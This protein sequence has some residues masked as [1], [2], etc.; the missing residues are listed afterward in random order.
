MTAP[1]E[2][3]ARVG[4]RVG[5]SPLWLPDRQVWL[6]LDLQGRF[7]HRFDPASATDTVIAR[8]LPED[9]ACLARWTPEAALLVSVRGFHRLEIATGRVTPLACPIDLPPGTIFNDGKV[10]RHGALWLGSSDAAEAAPLGRLWRIDR[11]RVT[12]VAAGFTVSNGP[13]FAPDGR[14]AWFADT[15]GRRLLRFTLDPD[16]TP[17]AQGDFARVPAEEGYPDGMTTDRDGT[18]YVGHWDG[19]RISRWAPDGRALPPIA[20]PARNVTALAF[21]GA[22]LGTAAITTAALFPGQTGSAK[23]GGHGDLF[24]FHGPVPG[25]PEPALG[26]DPAG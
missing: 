8:D 17:L 10:D 2:R 25:L 1:V 26:F 3:L 24:A 11:G 12:E 13:A 7:V 15:F 9:L 22:G 6:W 23:E 14:T 5:E 16:G 19:A 4:A 20:V 18:L 21:G